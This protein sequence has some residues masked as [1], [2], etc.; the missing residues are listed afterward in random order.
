MEQY[1]PHRKGKVEG[2][3]DFHCYEKSKNSFNVP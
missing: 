2:M 1:M 3:E